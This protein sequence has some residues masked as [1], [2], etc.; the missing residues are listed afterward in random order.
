MRAED[1]TVVIATRNRW[2]ELRSSLP[3]HETSVILVDNA[4]TDGTPEQVR[5]HFPLVEVI[6]LPRNRGAVARNIGL[7]EATT[8]LVA[9]ADDDSWWAPGALNRAAHL[10]ERHPRLGLLAARTLVGPEE[11]EDPLCAVMA[12]SPLG[13]APD[14]PGPSILGFAACAAVTRRSAFLSAGGFD[15]V[16][17]FMGEEERLALDLAALGWGISYV[18]SVVAHHHPTPR[19][20]RQQSDRKALVAR[21]RLLTAVLRRPWREV[22]RLAA[23]SA[24]EG[25]AGSLGVAQALVRMPQALAGRRLLPAQVET[26]RRLLD[27]RA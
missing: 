7:A 17:F 21:N 9:F 4:S 19:S 6:A 15:D 13:T 22:G 8:P 24:R 5:R 1:V 25:R 23:R 10:F 11:A 20:G 16:I 12:G 14:L 3:H 27:D 26:S 2:P 18:D